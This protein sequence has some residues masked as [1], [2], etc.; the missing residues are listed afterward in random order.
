MRNFLIFLMLLLVDS[1]GFSQERANSAYDF[2]EYLKQNYDKK[3]TRFIVQEMEHFI[4]EFPEHPAVS[5]V[6]YDLGFIYFQSDEDDET[7]GALLKALYSYPQHSLAD[8]AK[9]ALREVLAENAYYES[10]RDTLRSVLQGNFQDSS[11]ADNQFAYLKLL[12]QLDH[13]RI[14]QWTMSEMRKFMQRFPA[15][16]RNDQVSFW[17]ALVNQKEAFAKKRNIFRRSKGEFMET[18]AFFTRIQ[19]LYPK[20]PLIP[21]VKFHLAKVYDELNEYHS[22]IETLNELIVAYPEN[23]MVVPALFLIGKLTDEELKEPFQAIQQY[24]RIVDFYGNHPRA[25]EALEQI[26]ALQTEQDDY[27][28][29]IQTW[30]EI[31]QKYPA[32]PNAFAALKNMA[33]MYAEK[34]KQPD[35]TAATYRKF[36]TYFP[37]SLETPDMIFKAAQIYETEVKDFAK[38]LE[39]YQ[40]IN[41]K[42]PTHH[43]VLKARE[44]IAESYILLDQNDDWNLEQLDVARNE[45][46][47]NDLEK[48]IILEVNKLRSNPP[49]YAELYIEKLKAFYN[50]KLR[51]YPD[52]KRGYKMKEGLPAV[53]ACL[54]ALRKAEPRS[55]LMPLEGLYQAARDHVTDQGKTGATGHDGSDGSTPGERVG[56]YLDCS[57]IGENISYGYNHARKIVIQ[58]LL[59]DGVPSR[60]HRKNLLGRDYRF[61]GVACGKHKKYDFISVHDYAACSEIQQ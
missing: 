24:R 53:E 9:S 38:A 52:E 23:E 5:N 49:R 35:S 34:L 17:L 48:D 43:S 39:C 29:A 40:L 11:L 20:S 21:K 4:R 42:Y 41:E 26:V 44:K 28:G 12:Y 56:R 61:I 22:A 55:L 32:S 46:Y 25:P 16:P 58:L 15:D 14:V 51:Q 2:I 60:G 10:V 27:S 30:Q 13:F 45:T 18:V 8:S 57:R 6:Q 33:E 7:I 31:I 37:D 19:Y 3:I 47:L 59:D 36:D 1:S 50:G 54:E